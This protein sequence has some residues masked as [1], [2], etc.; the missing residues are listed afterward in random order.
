LHRMPSADCRDYVGIPHFPDAPCKVLGL[1]SNPSLSLFYSAIP[2]FLFSSL[3]FLSHAAI[4]HFSCR[5]QTVG[6]TQQYLLVY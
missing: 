3:T 6:I 1:R 4:P 2:H 5:R